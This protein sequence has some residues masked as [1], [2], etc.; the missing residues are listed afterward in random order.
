MKSFIGV[1]ALVLAI[2]GAGYA[3][4]PSTF[5]PGFDPRGTAVPYDPN[6]DSGFVSLFDGKTLKGWDGD[7]AVWSVRDGAIYAHPTCERPTS[8]VYMLWQGGEPANFILKYEMKGTQRVNGGMQFRS[9]LTAKPTGQVYPT[10]AP[11]PAWLTLGDRSCV[12]PGVPLSR[13]SEAEWDLFGPQADFDAGNIASGALYDQ[14]GRAVMSPPGHVLIAEPG[15]KI[16]SLAVVANK[17]AH[18]SWFHKNGW[19]QFVVVAYGRT[20]QIFMNDHLVTSF[21]D[22]DPVYF[23]ASGKLGIEVESTGE[24]WVR[25]IYLK[26]LK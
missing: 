26:S 7:T 12:K 18:D 11:Q 2:P 4:M 16:A 20:A 9:Y 15:A 14:G 19:N 17:S 5:P 10:V 8:T 23:R 22:L 6:D 13:A 21:L 25:N 3:Q 24:Y 1:A